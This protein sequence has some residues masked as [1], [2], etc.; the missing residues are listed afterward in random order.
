MRLDRVFLDSFGPLDSLDLTDL[1]PGLNVFLGPDAEHLQAFREFVRQVLFGFDVDETALVDSVAAPVGGLLEVVHSD[2]SPLTIERY[3][4]VSGSH[5]GQVSV[6]RAGES[7]PD[8]D[9]LR[10]LSSLDADSWSENFVIPSGVLDV[11]PGT[12]LRV[13]VSLLSGTD[14]AAAGPAREFPGP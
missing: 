9:A 1:S 6:S 2:G 3:L 5:A 13:I 12:L 11:E 14:G 7:R 10:D 4:R 8:A